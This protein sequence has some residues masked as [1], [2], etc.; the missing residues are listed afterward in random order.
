MLADLISNVCLAVG[1]SIFP[2]LDLK[3]PLKVWFKDEEAEDA[4]G[5]KKEFF[6]LLI[7][8]LLDPKYGMFTY[9]EETRA[10][11]FNGNSFESKDRFS[12]VGIICGLA[13]YNGRYL[14]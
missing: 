8:E 7:R 2:D 14:I 5:V 3:R 6:M 10:I 12:M 11:Y 1:K 4:G 9:Y 13:I